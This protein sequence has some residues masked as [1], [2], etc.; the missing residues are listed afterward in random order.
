M[1][2]VIYILFKVT[3]IQRTLF[4]TYGTVIS[5][6]EHNLNVNKSTNCAINIASAISIR[7][8]ILDYST[9]RKITS[10]LSRVISPSRSAFL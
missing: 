8:K 9:Q 1:K 10:K 4:V 2:I 5:I 7:V 3:I 6:P